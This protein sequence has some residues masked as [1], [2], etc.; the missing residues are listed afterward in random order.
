MFG[1][2]SYAKIKSVES[3]GSYSVCK[4]SISKKDKQS[5]TYETTFMA[6]VRFVG[7]AHNQRPLENQRIKILSCGVS[8]C[9]VQ[10]NELKFATV[11]NYVIF[12]YELQGDMPQNTN[13]LSDINDDNMPLPF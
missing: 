5:G 13:P 1:V 12:D 7:K 4:I 2:N 3:K 9:Y 6:K 11:P 8:N 10:D